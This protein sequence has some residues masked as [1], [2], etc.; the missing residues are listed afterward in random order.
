MDLKE[1]IDAQESTANILHKCSD[2]LGTGAGFKISDGKPTTDKAIIVF[3]EKKLSKRSLSKFSA[4]LP[5]DIDGIPIDVIEVGK[6]KKHALNTKV[7]PLKPGYSCGHINVT[8]GT[9]GGFFIDKDGDKVVLSNCHVLANEGNANVGDLIY[10]PGPLD[11]RADK[12]WKGWANPESLS[13][14]ATLKAFSNLN[15]SGV[16]VQDSA[17]AKIPDEIVN[18]NLIDFLY[19]SINKALNGFGDAAINMSVQKCGRTT[20]YTT[21]RV[22]ALNSEFGIQYDKGNIRF[23]KCI[24][25]TPLSQG[26][27]SGSLIL[28]HDM[29]VVGLLFGGSPKV[30]VANP[31]NII[32]DQYGLSL[33]NDTPDEIITL[34][35]GKWSMFT[36]Q[37]AS[38]AIGGEEVKFKARSNEFAC[39]ELVF[40]QPDTK[41]VECN[42]FTGTDG[43]ASWGPGITICWPDKSIK[44]NLRSGGT[45]GAWVDGTE[46]TGVGS[47]KPNTWYNLRVVIDNKMISLEADEADGND[48]TWS[49]VID[50][51]RMLLPHPPIMVR[52]GK[53][54]M[55]GGKSDH[56][57][58]GIDGEFIVKNVKVVYD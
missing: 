23:S 15:P 14:F 7:R 56:G 37:T 13:Y 4:P 22:I 36:S 18:A 24:V 26:G 35:N 21:G 42:I 31:F 8:C 12:S 25:T 46:Y 43:G 32:K 51:P 48:S 40:T 55:S 11:S 58:H 10:Q 41:L 3:V 17:I 20:G 29:N 44:V 5:S 39:M 6:L 16:N 1:V 52:I 53:T 28:N 45:F 9:I 38:Y 49:K 50:L 2:I 54:D 30:T 57:D 47:V 33:F 27:D 19:P 34:N